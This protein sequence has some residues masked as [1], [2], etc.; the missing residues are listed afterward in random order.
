MINRYVVAFIFD[1]GNNVWLIRKQKPEWQKGCLNGIGGKIE[2]EE[3]PTQAMY[4]ELWEE[5]GVEDA[6][7]HLMQV[8]IMEGVNND[9]SN[10]EVH[11]FTGNTDAIL[12]TKEVE[13]VGLYNINEVK[14]QKHIANVPALIELCKYWLGGSSNFKEFVL[15]Y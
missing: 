2:E 9:E 6:D 3:L 8:G 14:T 11:I 1:Y 4:R 15:K 7:C 13:E 10:F 5:T 12:Q